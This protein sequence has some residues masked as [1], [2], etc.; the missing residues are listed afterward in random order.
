MSSRMSAEKAIARH[1]VGGFNDSTPLCQAGIESLAILRIVA[2]AAVDTDL[3]ID[4]ARLVN[5]HTIGDLK[6]WLDEL[7]SGDSERAG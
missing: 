2:E 1:A 4:P 3:E 6:V 7:A 5:L